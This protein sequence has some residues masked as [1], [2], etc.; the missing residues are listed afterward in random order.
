MAKTWDIKGLRTVEGAER[1]VTIATVHE[2]ESHG[3]WMAECFV[4]VSV[5]SPE[6]IDWHFDD[7]LVYRDETFSINY[8]PNVVKKARRGSYGEG[9]VYDN[10]KLYFLGNKTKSYGF[11]DVV[12]HDNEVTYTSLA[13]FSFFCSSIEDFADR[14]QANF[15]RERQSSLIANIPFRVL[16]PSFLR[17]QQRGINITK[18]EW[19]R[20][21]DDNDESGGIHIEGETD[22]NIEIDKQ[23]C[24]DALKCS[25]EKFG[26]AYYFVGTTVVIGG[27]SIHVNTGA[28]NIFRYGKGL[29]LYEIERT[30][31]EQQEIVTKLFAYGSEQNLPLNYYA[32]LHKK[33]FVSGLKHEQG[34]Q[35]PDRQYEIWCYKTNWNTVKDA[36]TDKNRT[37]IVSDGKGH[38]CP[39]TASSVTYNEGVRLKLHFGNGMDYEIDGEMV[40]CDADS[41]F[42][43]ITDWQH[44]YF[45]YGAS[46][47][48]N[49][50]PADSIE[51][52][53]DYPK[54][55]SVNKLMLPGFPDESLKEWV[56]NKANI[57]A[58]VIKRREGPENEMTVPV[59][60]DPDIE[61]WRALLRKYAFSTD[62]HDPWIKSDNINAIG[63][64][65]GTV[66]YDGSQQKE[67]CP[68][69]NNTS[70]GVVTSGSNIEDNGYVTNP[71]QFT[72][73][74]A[75]D[76]LNWK[77]AL[78]NA[79]EEVKISMTSGFCTG[80]EFAVGKAELN[81]NKDAWILKLSRY[82]DTSL[83]RYFPYFD[84]DVSEYCQILAGDTFTVIGIQMPDEYIVAAS[85]K[86]L[87]AACGYLDKR[88]HMRYTYLPKIDE[89]FMQRDHD[90]RGE[91]SY[92]SIIRAGMQLEFEDSDLGIWHSPYIDQ[93]TIKENGNNGIPT[94]DVVLRDEKEKGSLEKLTD[95][96]SELM[97]NPPVQVVERQSYPSMN[98][99]YPEWVLGTPY[100]YQTLN[101]NPNPE[102]SDRPY[103]ETSYVWH[104]GKKWMCL[105]TLTT[106][107]PNFWSTDW[108][109]VE[110]NLELVGQIESSNGK[111]F[112]NGNV[113]STLTMMVWWGDE[114]IT[115]QVIERGGTF[116][117]SRR[118][119]Y[120]SET[121]QFVQ[122]SED[123]DWEPTVTAVNKIHLQ[124]RDMGPGWMIEYRQAMICCNVTFPD[125]QGGFSAYAEYIY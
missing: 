121:E 124:R 66:N 16:T 84:N 109:V 71:S 53:G 65:E 90:K 59:S 92:Y 61:P 51:E 23:D 99:D 12:L 48:L 96:I 5:K 57:N 95:S 22:I 105:R 28:Q 21:F 36:F 118:T 114:D 30:S 72:I 33:A 107:E 19:L 115:E 93:L 40:P 76:A 17:T 77:E 24:F 117:W 1:T 32:N 112:H 29:G 54:L 113:D 120:D 45:T 7:Y 82:Q 62:Q 8:D 108:K 13:T 100:Y 47:N 50:W 111:S 14:L 63:L 74:V 119:A 78:N 80:R 10:I 104:R 31:D 9:F 46:I 123:L 94:Y 110:G 2:I 56:C 83:S 11:K 97:A 55:L 125:G 42:N 18:D 25:Y 91:A 116:S 64:F 106:E 87:I 98:V 20:Y 43:A 39:C 81:E 44:L 4:T 69:I 85:E 6:P 41:F 15:N 26:L 3:E 101:T 49:S 122:Q 75:A 58:S 27:K 88:D 68:T 60:S 35:G 73:E 52:D 37:V 89:L 86:L 103:V 38:T 70:A 102:I 67:I 79:L 34:P